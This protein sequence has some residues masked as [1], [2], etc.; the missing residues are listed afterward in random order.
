[1]HMNRIILF[2]GLILIKGC[3]PTSNDPSNNPLVIGF[4]KDFDFE[5]IKS[6]HIKE[7]TDFVISQ[8]EKIKIETKEQK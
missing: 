6:G 8:A 3:A 2:I 4:N 1:M 7:G 5:N